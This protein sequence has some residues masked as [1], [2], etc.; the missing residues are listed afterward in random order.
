VRRVDGFNAATVSNQDVERAIAAQTDKSKIE[1]SC[2]VV[3]RPTVVVKGPNFCWELNATTGFWN[4]R[5]SA[6]IATWRASRSV[7]FNGNWCFGDTLTTQIVQASAS[8]FDELGASF[9]ARLESGPV[10]QYPS[11][12]R[13]LAAYF[14]FTSGQGTI[15]GTSDSMNPSVEVSSSIDGGGTWSTPVLRRDLGGQGQFQRMIRVNRIG[16]ITSQHGIRFRIDSSSPVYST[17]RG[18]RCDVLILKSA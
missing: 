7:Y 2:Y 3:G 11:R 14:D 1:M 9:T 6:N 5:Q 13:C 17:F 18:G 10:K 12:L 15:G 8:A 16:G 4:E